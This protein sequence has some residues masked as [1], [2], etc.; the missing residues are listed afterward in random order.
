MSLSFALSW[1]SRLCLFR[2]FVFP[3]LFYPDVVL[4]DLRYAWRG[5]RKARGFT[6]VILLT[7]ALGIGANT[8]IFSIVH[9][10]LIEPLP[11]RDADRLAFIWLGY[12][13]GPISG[14]DFRDIREGTSSFSE[15]GG[16]WASGTVALSGDGDPE[17]LRT[18]FVTTNFF[19]LLGAESAFGRTFREDDGRPGAPPT[20]LLG[21][22]LFTRRYGGDPSIVGRQILVND[23]PTTVVGVMPRAFRLLLPLDSGV[24]DHMQV[25]QP[26]WPEFETGPRGNQ[27]MRAIGRMRPGVTIAQARADVDAVA[28]TIAGEMGTTRAFTTVGLQADD[29]RE[30]PR[31]AAVALR[32]RRH[33]ADDRVRQRRRPADRARRLARQG[34]G[35]APGPRR[36]P[37]TAAAAVAGRRI[38]AGRARCCRRHRCRVRGAEAAARARARI[39]RPTDGL[40]PRRDGL[41]LHR[42]DLRRSG[43][44]CSRWRPLPRYSGRRGDH[45]SCS[46]PAQGGCRRRRSATA[47]AGRCS[48]CRLP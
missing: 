20:I 25:W 35:A 22:D 33:P 42:R 24:P 43:A 18:S 27:F 21:W 15:L 14:P 28:R 38:A 16:I 26:F 19:Q 11:Y 36:E 31:T 46:P 8:T 47:R 37:R 39:A 40:G 34:N 44:C 29:T 13:R 10:M 9:A 2:V 7:L 32:R 41:F 45:S 48:W 23:E 6:A 5:I 12:S 30:I 1:L 4:L 17:E 3:C